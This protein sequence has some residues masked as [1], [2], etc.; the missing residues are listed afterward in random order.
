MADASSLPADI[1]VDAHLAPEVEDIAV[2]ALAALGVSARV[3]VL[4]PR[5]GTSELQWVIL[6]A[7]P[8]QAFLTGIGTKIADDAYKG[9]QE[10]VRKLRRQ[11]PAD[12]LPDPPPM[13]LQDSASGLRI[14]LDH[15]LPADGYQQLLALDVSQYRL[16]PVHY[17]RAQ[18][19]WRSELDEATPR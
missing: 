10:A 11:E 8:L 9:F 1:F 13:V 3:R 14:V 15:D 17:D 4:S 7:L 2:R 18:R 5:R 19:R 12:K 16:G 6:A